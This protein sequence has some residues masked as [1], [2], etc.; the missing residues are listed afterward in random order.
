MPRPSVICRTLIR[1]NLL[2]R[3]T[4]SFS[5]GGGSGTGL[6]GSG[7]G[8]L[9]T[10]PGKIYLQQ[11]M[12]SNAVWV[13]FVYI[14]PCAH[15]VDLRYLWWCGIMHSG[16]LVKRVPIPDHV[17]LLLLSGFLLWEFGLFVFQWHH[18]H[19][20][21][22]HTESFNVDQ[23]RRTAFSF[24][25]WQARTARTAPLQ[26]TGNDSAGSGDSAPLCDHVITKFGR[27]CAITHI[28]QRSRPMWTQCMCIK[29]QKGH[30]RKAFLF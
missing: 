11:T 9:S 10:C 14:L 30:Q 15:F 18:L 4:A 8:S 5:I 6:G 20:D 29:S 1:M 24:G 19:L 3:S 25:S 12:D 13:I 26:P 22:V 17:R 28:C 21:I 16:N 2:L 7:G 27:M 23:Y